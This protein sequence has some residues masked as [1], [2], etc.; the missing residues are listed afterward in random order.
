MSKPEFVEV[1]N[2][3]GLLQGR[4]QPLGVRGRLDAPLPH[5]G[6]PAEALH[7]R[8]VQ[9]LASHGQFSFG[10]PSSRHS[11]TIREVRTSQP[12]SPL[13]SGPPRW[14]SARNLSMRWFLRA[15]L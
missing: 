3:E 2:M 12:L 4:V 7:Q 11:S 5:L 10:A 13:S 8:S 15:R 6:Y 1:L 14:C 9:V